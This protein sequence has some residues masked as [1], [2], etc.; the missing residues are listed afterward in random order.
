VS[1]GNDQSDALMTSRRTVLGG[2][3]AGLGALATGCRPHSSPPAPPPSGPLGAIDTFVVVMME[4]RS[5]DHLL[6]ALALD[7]DYPGRAAVDGLRGGESNRDALGREVAVARRTDDIVVA[8]LRPAWDRSHAAWNGGRNDGF[9]RACKPHLA[10]E[11]MTYHDRTLAPLHYALAD[12]YTV[13]DRWFASLLGPTWPNRMYLHAGTALGRRTNRLHL[14]GPRTVWE[15]LAARGIEA[16]C[17]FG[18]LISWYS[19]AF[20]GKTLAGR[21]ALLP[22]GLGSFF[23]DARNGTLPPFSVVD[24]DFQIND[25]HPPCRLVFGEAFL[26]SVVRA[27]EE[28]PQ[29]RRS[30]LLVIYDEH[31]GFYDHVPPPRTVDPDPA[32]AQLGFRVPALAIG[33]TV[34]PGAVVS[35]QFDHT[36]VLA[37]LR[38][39]F[40]IE[41][42]G[43]RMDAANDL[44]SV[45][46]PPLVACAPRAR[47]VDRLELRTDE[48][49]ACASWSGGHEDM[50]AVVD[51]GR[52]PAG[53]FNAQSAEERVRAWL[54]VAQELDV[55]RVRG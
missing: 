20:L 25:L 10:A 47:G 4:N 5:F 55:V 42:L 32:F 17:Y 43:P 13:C 37:T 33:P 44:S 39:R 26:A 8:D 35:T 1:D 19:M 16:R 54:R 30:L 53:H 24:P 6:G 18:G 34:R 2:L 40:G 45:L 11:V 29:W 14:T 12:R 49:L 15:A 48:L 50:A 9:A 21:G 3:A 31:G 28:S 22:T 41:S 23:R 52:V 27:L 36:S 51:S 46:D 7:R 38:A